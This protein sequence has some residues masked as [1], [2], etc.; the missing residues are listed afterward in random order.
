[1]F[2]I[3]V[4]ALRDPKHWAQVLVKT[5]PEK[6]Y[7]NGWKERRKQQERSERGKETVRLE[8]DKDRQW[9]NTA[10]P[11]KDDNEAEKRELEKTV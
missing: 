5:D 6:P 2:G 4:F 7:W 11:E 1:M 10:L 9:I 8:E 3:T